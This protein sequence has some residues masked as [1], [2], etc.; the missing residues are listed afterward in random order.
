MFL[1]DGLSYRFYYNQYDD[2][3]RI[4]LPT[5]GSIKY[6]Y[7]PGLDGPKPTRTTG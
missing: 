7:G 5:G 4:D 3:T 6:E 2:L 1:P